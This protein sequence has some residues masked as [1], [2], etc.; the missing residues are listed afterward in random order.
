MPFAPSG[1][2]T[3]M[4]DFGTA[5]PFAGIVSGRILSRSPGAR[6]IDLGHGMPMG[7][8]D[9]AGFW[10]GRAWRD[11]PVGTLHLAVV[12]PGVGTARRVLLALAEDRLLLAPD[13]GL[14]AEALRDCRTA[15]YF[16]MT[17]NLPERLGLTEISQTFHGRDLF[18][19]LAAALATGALAPEDFGPPTTPA[20]PTPLPTPTRDAEG[21][22]GEILLADHFGNLFT[23]IGAPLVAACRQ[24]WAIVGKHS[25]AVRNTYADVPPGTPLALVNAFGVLE[26]AINGASAAT[27]LELAPGTRIRLVDGLAA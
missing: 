14:L 13:N 11:F 9:L 2:I 4:T 18:A 10:L 22:G 23:N 8:P 5:D 20:D 7:R 1:L 27:V 15:R 19:P 25:L 26:L 16:A 24:P 17:A 21:I 6:I 12:D 3:L